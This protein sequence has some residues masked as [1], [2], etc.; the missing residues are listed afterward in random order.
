M[1]MAIDEALVRELLQEQLPAFAD[2]PILP[3]A[4][5]GT[6]NAIF[7]VGG[8]HAAR[9]PKVDWAAAQPAREHRWLA[10]LAAKLPLPIP[11]SIALGQ[12]NLRYPW[13][14]SLHS[15]IAG[16]GAVRADLQNTEAAERLGRFVGALRAI[17]PAAGPACGPEN[18][19]RGV[20][21]AQRD[22]SVRRALLQLRDEPEIETLHTA[23]QDALSAPAWAGEPI[24][25]HG[26]LQ[27]SNVIIHQGR[28]A[29]VIDFGLMGLGD[30]ACDLMAGWTCF[31]GP[32][33]RIFL[34]A[35]RADAADIRRGRGW[36]IS[37]ALVALAHYRDSNPIMAEMSR[38]TLAEARRD[39]TSH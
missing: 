23:W 24:W 8:S 17:D 22:V 31:A 38:S 21:L 1:T 15:W 14:W 33:R 26:D 35:A 32:M 25:L 11:K 28:L 10:L 12:P 39:F 2:L 5:T 30:P 7:K 9:L 3:I 18:G 4:S 6:D 20:S 34:S 16:R 19:H 29:A 37:T 13:H 27:P 36:A